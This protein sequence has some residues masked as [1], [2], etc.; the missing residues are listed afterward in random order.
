MHKKTKQELIRSII[1]TSALAGFIFTEMNSAI[2]VP[3][4][5]VGHTG[6]IVNLT[7]AAHWYSA[8]LP[9]DGASL[10]LGNAGVTRI[11]LD[12][13]LSFQAFDI[14]FFLMLSVIEI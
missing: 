13:P 5:I 12:A 11:N 2:A 10:L 4:N 9:I 14:E 7:T 6:G 3:T 1:R 8:T